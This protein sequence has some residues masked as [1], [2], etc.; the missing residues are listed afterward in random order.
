MKKTSQLLQAGFPAVASRKLAAGIRSVLLTDF[1][2]GKD[3]MHLLAGCVNGTVVAIR[4]RQSAQDGTA[5]YELDEPRTIG[6]GS[7]PVT[8]TRHGDRVFACGSV[9]T[10]LYWEQGRLQQSTLAVKVRSS[11][12]RRGIVIVTRQQDVT[13]AVP[14]HAQE[15]EDATIFIAPSALTFGRVK[16]V[17]RLHIK[18]V[19]GILFICSCVLIIQ[20]RSRSGWTTQSALHTACARGRL[21]LAA[22]EP[23]PS[24]WAIQRLLHLRSGFWIK[25]RLTVRHASLAC[26]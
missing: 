11:V 1:G 13:R 19:G 3:N 18:T 7:L 24:E 15:F 8:L 17:Q 2:V 23:S 14:L 6:L 25:T 16:Q 26:L 4:V 21:A 5:E 22:C 9:V 10:V 12:T 20:Y